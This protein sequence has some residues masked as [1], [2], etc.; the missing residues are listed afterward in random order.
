MI[1][2]FCWAKVK[3]GPALRLGGGRAKRGP[4]PRGGQDREGG[5]AKRGPRPRGGG[6][7]KRGVEGQEWANV[8]R[9]AGPIGG[10]G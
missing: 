5:S 6:K 4:E 2:A 3:R 8:E 9:G 7:A 1:P 10:Q